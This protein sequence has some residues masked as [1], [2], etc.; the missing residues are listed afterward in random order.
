MPVHPGTSTIPSLSMQ[1][2]K[3]DQD[4]KVPGNKKESTDLIPV[5]PTM[6]Y[7][8]ILVIVIIAKGA[9]FIY[10]QNLLRRNNLS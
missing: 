10:C 9:K 4:E 7:W 3:E 6:L 5:F 1:L 8:K 2:M